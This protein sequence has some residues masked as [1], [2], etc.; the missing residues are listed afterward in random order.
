FVRHVP[1]TSRVLHVDLLATRPGRLI[2]WPPLVLLLRLGALGLFVVTLLAGLIGNQNPY[3]NI[4]P[5][6]VW[7]IFWVGLAY[8]SAFAGNFWALINPWRTLFDAAERLYRLA[9]STE[10][11]LRLPYPSALGAWPA[12]VLLLAFAWI[13]LVYAS[14]A[15]PAHIAC[16]GVAYS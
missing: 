8:V 4:A 2:A 13:E 7:I 5:T 16:F 3:R 10:R 11:T 12:C 9:G 15:V 1:D 6:L 14:P